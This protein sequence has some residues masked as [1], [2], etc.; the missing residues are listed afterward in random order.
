M[1]VW[2]SVLYIAQAGESLSEEVSFDVKK[3]EA[4]PRSGGKALRGRESSV[5]KGA[6][7]VCITAP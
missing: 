1:T 5:C 4:V 7:A 6:E 2:E 3:E